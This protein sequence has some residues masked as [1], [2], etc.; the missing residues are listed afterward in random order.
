[1]IL[2]PSLLSCDFSTLGSVVA[3]LENAGVQWLHLDIM[4][5]MFVPNITFGPPVIGCLRQKTNLFFDVHLMI[6]EPSRYIEDF[7]KA[8]ADLIVIHNE[9]ETHLERT[10]AKIKG[11]GV[12]AG[13]AYNP[14]STFMNLPWLVHTIDLVLLMS[15]NPGFSGQTFLPSTYKKIERCR[16]LL[17]EYS[18]SDVLIEV[19]GGVTPDNCAQLVEAGA[20]VLVSGSSF[21]AHPPYNTRLEAFMSRVQNDTT[22]NWKHL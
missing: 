22:I 1:M 10:L 7:V 3:E 20:C 14:G 18:A 4:D 12:K 19:D 9:A 15:V 13:I 5:G 21:F 17:D 2:A 16:K 11:L 6:E 8:G